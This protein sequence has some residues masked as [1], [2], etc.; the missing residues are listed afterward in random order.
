MNYKA[1]NNF[2]RELPAATYVMQ[3]HNSHVWKVG[4]KVFAIGGLEGERGK[5][6]NPAL[7][8]K[9]S[10]LNFYFLSEITGYKPAPYFASREMKWTQHDESNDDTDDDYT[11]TRQHYL[12]KEILSSF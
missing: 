5:N 11:C 4:G 6:D 1:F 3:W 8:F 10:E 12:E 7:I 9:T 2:C